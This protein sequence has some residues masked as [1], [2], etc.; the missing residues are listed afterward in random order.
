MKDNI[1]GSPVLSKGKPE[2]KLEEKLGSLRKMMD[3]AV[4]RKLMPGG[5]LLLAQHG[6]IIFEEYVGLADREEGIPFSP[7]TIKFYGSNSKPLS[8]TAIMTLVDSGKFALDDQVSNYLPEF[9]NLK[10]RGTNEHVDSPT[11]RQCLSMSSGI[12]GNA[13]ATATQFGILRQIDLTLADSVALVAREALNARPGTYYSYSGASYQVVGRIVEV[14][15][16]KPFEVF[17]RE[18]L[19]EPLGFKDVQFMNEPIN[20]KRWRRLETVYSPNSQGT[21]DMAVKMPPNAKGNLTLVPGAI[22]GTCKEYLSFL[23]MHLNGGSYGKATMLSN[24]L[25]NEMRKMHTAKLDRSGSGTVADDYGIAWFLSRTDDKGMARVY[26]HAGHW[27]TY[28]WID[29]DRDMVGFWAT[30]LPLAATVPIME[31]VYNRIL[32]IFPG[33]PAPFMRLN[34]P[35]TGATEPPVVDEFQINRDTIKA[36]ESANLSFHINGLDLKAS[37]EPE[38]GNLGVYSIGFTEIKGVCSVS[39]VITTTYKLVASNPVGQVS[40]SVTLTVN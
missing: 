15:T 2:K 10:L 33:Q 23:Q 3:D 28:G 29:L 11:I 30:N 6:E 16:G 13:E 19:S 31:R 1:S 14:I 37:I 38:I 24:T 35:T 39:P 25:V 8:A 5:S 27:G 34:A 12:F 36:G 7:E 18:C 20:E 21:F 9:G 26:Q 17:F 4:A 22:I 40:R 32:D